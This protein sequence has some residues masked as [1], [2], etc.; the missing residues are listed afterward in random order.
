[1]YGYPSS[2]HIILHAATFSICRQE[3]FGY[4]WVLNVNELFDLIFYSIVNKI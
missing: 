3:N 4:N 2:V 1:M